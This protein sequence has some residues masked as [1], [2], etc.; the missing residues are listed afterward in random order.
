ME[1]GTLLMTKQMEQDKIYSQTSIVE[2]QCDI[3]RQRAYEKRIIRSEIRFETAINIRC[4][5]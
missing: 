4:I 2:R 3:M 1:H 5:L